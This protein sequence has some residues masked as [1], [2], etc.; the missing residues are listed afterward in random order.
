MIHNNI[1]K[2]YYAWEPMIIKINNNRFKDLYR[3]IVQ[4]KLVQKLVQRIKYY[5]VEQRLYI[6]VGEVS[7]LK[8]TYND[9]T[10]S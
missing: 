7:L 2:Y 4:I 3:E 1:I 9:K 10:L 5:I 6:R 8:F